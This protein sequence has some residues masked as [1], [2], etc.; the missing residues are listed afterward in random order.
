M[1]K[2]GKNDPCPCGSGRKYKKCC[3]GNKTTTIT[4]PPVLSVLNP[5][6][7]SSDFKQSL[8]PDR[9]WLEDLE[10][11]STEE[12]IQQLEEFG[13]PFSKE[14]FLEDVHKF[15]SAWALGVS[16]LDDN[17]IT[18]LGLD[19]DFVCFAPIVLWKRLA[20]DVINSE[21]LDDMMQKGYDI[22]NDDPEMCTLWLEVWEHLKK[23]FTPDMKSIEDAEKV[24]SGLQSLFNWTQDLEMEL[25]NA[26]LKD[27]SFYEKRIKYCQEFCELFPES[28][29]SFILNM[30]RA[31]AESYFALGV[32]E[33]GDR[34]FQELVTEF[35]ESAWSYIGWGDMYGE[36]RYKTTP[37]DYEKAKHI[38]KLGLE[39][40]SEH[41]DDLIDR[42]E[43]L[44]KENQERSQK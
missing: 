41:K 22:E 43:E 16:W 21:M 5:N 14:K 12:I 25:G 6:L 34:L 3:M 15:Y 27:P 18:G 24:F 36:L 37:F 19:E 33:E 42:L 44:E 20:P 7:P 31:I 35:P 4:A 11:M 2:T 13:V 32:T 1:A 30:K 28:G 40:A 9:W 8:F 10:E 23:R 17:G 39:K 26:G 38:Y 29:S